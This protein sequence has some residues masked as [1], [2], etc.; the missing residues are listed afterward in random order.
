LHYTRS[1]LHMDDRSVLPCQEMIRYIFSDKW[2]RYNR[3]EN[4]QR[5]F[6][7]NANE[8]AIVCMSAP[9]TADP[10]TLARTADPN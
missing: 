3:N 6:L 7:Y 9:R 5:P 10:Y 2:W 4:Y 8:R 1:P